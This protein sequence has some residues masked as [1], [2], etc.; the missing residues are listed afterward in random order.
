M[1]LGEKSCLRSLWLPG[2]PVHGQN[3][4]LYDDDWVKVLTRNRQLF[5]W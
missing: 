4:N 5:S 2:V 1:N 3:A